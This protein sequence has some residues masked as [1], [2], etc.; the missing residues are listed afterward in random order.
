MQ[1]LLLSSRAKIGWGIAAGAGLLLLVGLVQAGT[2]SPFTV[3]AGLAEA[4]HQ[5]AWQHALAGQAEPKPW[6]WEDGASLPYTQVPQLG[7]SATVVKGTGDQHLSPLPRPGGTSGRDVHKARA[8]LGDVAIGDRITVTAA[9]GSSH[10]YKV[11]GRRVV[12]PHLAEAE[13]AP[14]ESDVSLLTCAPLESLAG[15]LRLII[16]A[17]E[18]APPTPEPAPAA[19][20]KL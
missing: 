15:S 2:G 6:P 7:L 19:E 12:D 4:L 16:Q 18:A 8:E 1:F 9:D 14:P 20:Q 13:A 10:V 17:T 5:S 11:T 3:R